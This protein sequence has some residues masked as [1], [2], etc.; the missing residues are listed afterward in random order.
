MKSCCQACEVSHLRDAT[1]ATIVLHL[2]LNGDSF[3][4]GLM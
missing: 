2:N 3:F 4:L 1:S